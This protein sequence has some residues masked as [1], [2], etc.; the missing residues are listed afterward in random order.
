[1]VIQTSDTWICKE[2]FGI[3]NREIKMNNK[4]QNKKAIIVGC[5]MSQDLHLPLC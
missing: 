1:M 5:G 3:Q 2:S 4:T